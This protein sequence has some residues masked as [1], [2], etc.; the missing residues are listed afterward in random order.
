MPSAYKIVATCL[1]AELGT[2]ANVKNYKGRARVDSGAS[3]PLLLPDLINYRSKFGPGTQA[4][5]QPASEGVT[6]KVQLG[7]IIVNVAILGL[8]VLNHV[9]LVNTLSDYP[10]RFTMD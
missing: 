5:H 7:N 1:L 8:N 2:S 3:P 6:G 10:D 9:L 4:C